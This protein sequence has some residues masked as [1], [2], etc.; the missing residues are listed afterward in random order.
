MNVP[1][2]LRWAGIGLGAPARHNGL[3]ENL[4]FP[5][6]LI[7]DLVDEIEHALLAQRDAHAKP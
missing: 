6:G 4:G 5:V 2:G 1:V 3:V 7:G